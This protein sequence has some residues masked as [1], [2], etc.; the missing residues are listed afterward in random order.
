[1]N[2]W[3]NYKNIDYV[4]IVY[5]LYMYQNIGICKNKLQGV[6][7]QKNPLPSGSQK[8][9]P[10]ASQL[11]DTNGTWTKWRPLYGRQQLFY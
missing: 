1:M 6:M 3:W 8:K 11:L 5:E 2:P 7:F 10:R 4:Y 9:L